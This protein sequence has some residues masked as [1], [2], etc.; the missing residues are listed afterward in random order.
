MGCGDRLDAHPHPRHHF[1]VPGRGRTPSRRPHR[2]TRAPPRARARTSRRTP[3]SRR[4]SATGLPATTRQRPR[5]TPSPAPPATLRDWLQHV[6]PRR[7]VQ[8]RSASPGSWSR[9]TPAPAKPSRPGTGSMPDGVIYKPC[10]NRRAAVCPACAEV[11]RADTYQLVLAGLQGGKGVCGERPPP[12][13]RLPHP[14]RTLLRAGPL[15][16]QG[17]PEPGPAARPQT[18]A[19]PARRRP[20]PRMH[21][22][23]ED[24]R[25]AALPG[26]LRPHKPCGTASPANS[27]RLQARIKEHR[28]PPRQ[29][30]R[31]AVR[32]CRSRRSP[33]CRPA[34]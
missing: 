12:P 19:L 8:R 22:D 33:R 11:Y 18:A 26:L 7:R 23:G 32:G 21:A 13:L 5:R 27:G 16:D 15:E 31:T 30:P 20:A 1:P 34:P 6:A 28:P 17:R 25:P 9:S 3:C 14:H 4:C 29:S 10:G 2:P 24:P